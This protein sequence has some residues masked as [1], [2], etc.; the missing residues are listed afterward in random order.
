MQHVLNFSKKKTNKR[1]RLS[2]PAHTSRVRAQYGIHGV[3]VAAQVTGRAVQ[4][5][6]CRARAAS[7]WLA[8]TARK[9]PEE[10]TPGSCSTG[11]AP[12]LGVR[13]PLGVAE[14]P[15]RMQ[16]CSDCLLLSLSSEEKA[17]LG[18]GALFSCSLSLG[19]ARVGGGGRP[20]ALGSRRGPS[21]QRLDVSEVQ[22]SQQLHV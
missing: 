15:G 13:L 21:G 17:G 18:A 7:I 19:E 9:V 22:L 16:K 6:E 14:L 2:I 10:I 5:E 8:G 12:L 11:W 4:G 20:L 1:A 3:Y